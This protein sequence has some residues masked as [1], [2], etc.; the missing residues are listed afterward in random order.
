M[1]H[2]RFA[3]PGTACLCLAATA[4]LAGGCA[5]QAGAAW[6]GVYTIDRTGAAKLCSAPPAAPADGT[7]I[8]VQIQENND[9]GWCGMFITRGGQPFDSYLMMTRPMHGRLLAHKV[10]GSTRI[11]YTPDAGFTGT[12]SYAIRLIPGNAVVEG[13]VIVTP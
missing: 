1:K 9:G 4:L 3:L 13:T 12:D 7:A 2:T 6:D 11:D 5:P 10:G 8:K